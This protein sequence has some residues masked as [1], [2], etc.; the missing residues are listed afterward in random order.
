MQELKV[1]SNLS[2]KV[3]RLKHIFKDKIVIV[4]FSGGVDSTLLAYFALKFSKKAICVFVR[5][6]SMSANERENAESVASTLGLDF[7]IIDNN[8][9]KNPDFIANPPNRCYFCKKG[10]GK[11]LITFSQSIQ[12]ED[13]LIVEGTNASELQGHRPGKKA[14]EELG[15]QS[16][17]A[18]V[19]LSKAEIRELARK[20]GLPN[21][22]KP[23]MACLS[24]R[25]AYGLE[26]TVERLG[27]IAKAEDYLAQEGIQI[28]RVRDHGNLARIE[29]GKDERTKFFDLEMMDRVSEYLKQIGFTYVCLDLEGYRTG[30]MNE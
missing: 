5:D 10:L 21:S 18:D 19:N 28:I 20:I 11:E 14:L 2:S 22:E 4:A 27:R 7:R 29:I 9:F 15:I 16:P 6:P 1:N 17:L 12:G 13:V 24:S 8:E 26:I 23:S 25:V 3:E 30:A